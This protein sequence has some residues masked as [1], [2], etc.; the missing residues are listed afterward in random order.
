M[1]LFIT[2]NNGKIAHGIKKY[3]CDTIDDLPLE[4]QGESIRPGSEAYI[5]DS[6]K[7]YK[8]TSTGQWVE[9]N[10]SGGGAS[11]IEDLED[12]NIEEPTDGQVLKYDAETETWVNGDDEG[13]ASLAGLTD[14][15]L[16]QL[17]DGQTL[18]YDSTTEKWVNVDLELLF[19]DL[20]GTL[21]AG[22]TTLT[23]SDQRITTSSVVELF[24]RD[25]IEI[26]YDSISI[27]NGSATVTLPAQAANVNIIM[28]LWLNN[29]GGLT[30]GTSACDI[31]YDNTSSG[32]SAINVQNAI[33]ELAT[34]ELIGT[35]EINETTITFTDASIVSGCTIDV[36]VDEAFLGVVPTAQVTDGTNHTVTLTFPVQASNMPVKVRVS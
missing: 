6:K 15:N 10:V 1:A 17:A 19:V 16:S 30:A 12:V 2:A 13:I 22:Q 14:V 32:L 35:L 18:V 36:Y 5:A 28:R 8:Y 20:E 24:S 3:L 21:L 11:T 23:F 34:T 31:T 33:D 7:T 4:V 25:N 29:T 27:S 9:I 26:T